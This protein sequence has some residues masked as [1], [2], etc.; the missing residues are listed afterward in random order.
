MLE[1][2]AKRSKAVL[3]GSRCPGGPVRF[4]DF[5]FTTVDC[6]VLPEADDEAPGDKGVTSGDGTSADEGVND[7][8]VRPTDT[9]ECVVAD[10][11]DACDSGSGGESGAVSS[12]I[13]KGSGGSGARHRASARKPVRFP[14][15][16]ATP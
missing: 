12:I 5:S 10:G 3:A 8:D 6:S 15:S 11:N 4:F 13:G 9:D 16:P 2:M 7:G 14:A 1:S